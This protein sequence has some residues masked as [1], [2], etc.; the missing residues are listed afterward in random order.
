MKMFGFE[1]GEAASRI[2]C[3]ANPETG[4]EEQEWV[5][6]KLDDVDLS[7]APKL[8]RGVAGG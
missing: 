3:V 8:K 6:G 4:V 7:G 2:E 1:P 5:W